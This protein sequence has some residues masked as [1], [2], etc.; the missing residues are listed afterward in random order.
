MKKKNGF[1]LIELLA[2]IIILGVLML[3]AIPSVTSYINNSRK[4][5]YADTAANYIKGATNLVNEGVKV[6]A[7]DEGVLYM[8]PVGHNKSL[9]CV[10]LE[11][12]GQSPYNT[13]YN[14]AYVGVTYN[15]S[16]GSYTYYFTSVDGSG[17][18][19]EFV[20]S[21]EIS[22]SEKDKGSALV[23]AGLGKY[24]NA[25][26]DTNKLQTLYATKEGSN[27]AAGLS[28]NKKLLATGGGTCPE[29]PAVT[30][31]CAALGADAADKDIKA[32]LKYASVNEGKTDKDETNA[33]N[34]FYKVMYVYAPTSSGCL[35]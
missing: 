8:I 17:Q 22:S 32:M 6:Q 11:S 21:Y 25:S 35:G 19:F 12:G 31:D 16:K 18:G 9:S 3:V 14:M 15:N 29:T 30:E 7:Y 28:K 10:Q 27:Q 33:N 5:A 1:T 34:I 2:V 26:G 24:S 4:S 13:E 20:S 23:K